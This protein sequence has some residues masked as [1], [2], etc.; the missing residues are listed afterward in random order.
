MKKWKAGLLMLVAIVTMAFGV[1]SQ[2][3]KAEEAIIFEQ[4]PITIL[5]DMTDFDT[6]VNL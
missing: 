1:G 5:N 6:D 2:E 3:V 4:V